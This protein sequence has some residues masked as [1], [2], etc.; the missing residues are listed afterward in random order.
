M[1]FVEFSVTGKKGDKVSVSH[2]EVLD[3]DGNF[4]TDN[5]RTAKQKIEYVLNGGTEKYHARMTFQG[6]RYIRIESYP[7][8][9]KPENFVAHVVSSDMNRIGYFESSHKLLNQLLFVNTVVYQ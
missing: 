3:K 5:L 6:F 1:G 8:E 2:A 4:Y 9:I 7:G